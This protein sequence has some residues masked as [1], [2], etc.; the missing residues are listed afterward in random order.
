MARKLEFNK[1]EKHVHNFML[2]IQYAKE[3]RR[4][5][6]GTLTYPGA[7]PSLPQ[8]QT[9]ASFPLTLASSDEG[10]GSPSAAGGLAVLQTHTQEGYR[11]RPKTPAQAAGCYQHVSASPVWS[12]CMTFVHMGVSYPMTCAYVCPVT[13]VH[14][15]TP[16]SVTY[17]LMCVL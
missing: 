4:G 8:S 17:V 1:A 7:Q 9:F 3:V 5:G 15:C 14:V 10:V 6:S 12:A 2:D 11:L 16:S 13:C